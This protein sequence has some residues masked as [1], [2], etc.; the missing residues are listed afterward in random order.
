MHVQLKGVEAANSFPKSQLPRLKSIVL[1]YNETC[2]ADKTS[3]HMTLLISKDW[4][5]VHWNIL[6]LHRNHRRPEFAIYP[7]KGTKT[8]LDALNFHELSPQN[9][10]D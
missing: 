8:N 1:F 4:G 6:N 7:S 9:E 2:N 10:N 5:V 3:N